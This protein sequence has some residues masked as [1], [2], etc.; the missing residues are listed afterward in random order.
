MRP[1]HPHGEATSVWVN[2]EAM[3]YCALI[4]LAVL[5]VTILILAVLL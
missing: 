5:L 2:G 4:L 3:H 1:S